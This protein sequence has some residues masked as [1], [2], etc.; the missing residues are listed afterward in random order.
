MRILKESIIVAF[1][2]VGVVVGAGFATG[3]EIFQFFTSHGAYSISGII[4]TGLL[5]TL[6][7]MVVMHTGHHLKSRN[8]S[9]SINYFL[10][11]SI[12]RGFDIISASYVYVVFSYYDCRWCVNHSSKFQLTVLAE[13]THISRLYFSNTVSK[14]RSFNCCAWRCYPIF[15]CDC[16]YDC[17]LLFH[18]KSS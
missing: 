2:F 18:N 6:G 16:H 3:Q 11:P 9:D 7:G 8:H 10:Y 13:R 4:V 17:G 1:A 14:I 5:I 12:A 15:N